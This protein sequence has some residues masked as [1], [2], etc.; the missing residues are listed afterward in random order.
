MYIL[1]SPIK[2][3]SHLINDIIVTIIIIIK[4]I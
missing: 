3:K 2:D 1:F 4:I